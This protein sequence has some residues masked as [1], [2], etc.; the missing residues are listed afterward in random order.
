MAAHK[1]KVWTYHVDQPVFRI[2]GNKIR[3]GKVINRY[4]RGE[5]SVNGLR[6]GP[7]PELYDVQFEDGSISKAFLPH[8]IESIEQDPY[9]IGDNDL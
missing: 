6:L 9:S 5:T 3:K 1:E 4:S 8:G 2:D 7:Y